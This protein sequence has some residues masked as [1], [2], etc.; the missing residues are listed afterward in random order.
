MVFAPAAA[1]GCDHTEGVK[2]VSM[3]LALGV[4]LLLLCLGGVS[5]QDELAPEAEDVAPDAHAELDD[6]P[7]ILEPLDPGAPA[8]ETAPADR[9]W[10]WPT[11]GRL[12]LRMVYEDLR[13][14]L[15]VDHVDGTDD[16]LGTRQARRRIDYENRHTSARLEAAYG[17]SLN[18]DLSL[19]LRGGLGWGTTTITVES[20]GGSDLS[21]GG[22]DFDTNLETDV[23]FNLGFGVDARWRS[24]N[25]FFGAS[26]SLL[27][28][29][30][31]FDD[32][33]MFSV[34]EGD[35]HYLTQDVY[36]VFG[37]TLGEVVSFW[38]GAGMVLYWNAMDLDERGGP[39]RWDVNLEEDSLFKALLGVALHHGPL[40]AWAQFQ[41]VPKP[42]LTLGIGYTF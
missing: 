3:R 31:G 20:K 2:E 30:G 24:G 10:V 15:E 13:L 19:S 39:D 22:P 25:L 36:G 14:D 9:A 18:D 27:Y 32:Q 7:Q 12:Q 5:A 23:D 17:V 35:I 33:I 41:F 38:G 37:V 26:Y 4:C 1:G 6:G 42:S 40:T 34:V 28:G 29:Y 11:H 8:A 21:G 16:P